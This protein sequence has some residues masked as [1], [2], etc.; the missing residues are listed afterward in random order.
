MSVILSNERKSFMVSETTD[1]T[2]A[3]DTKTGLTVTDFWAVWCGPCKMQAPILDQL[4]NEFQHQIKFN[5]INVDNNPETP[6]KLGIMSIPTLIVK[7]NGKIIN[8]IVGYRNK[9]QLKD[10]F[11]QYLED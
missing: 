6:Q 9:K 1:D 2:F 5:K 11:N 7:K 3:K 4:S 10:I 8:S